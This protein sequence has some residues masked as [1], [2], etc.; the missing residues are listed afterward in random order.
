MDAASAGAD[1]IAHLEDD[2]LWRPH[3]LRSALDAVAH[4]NADFVSSSSELFSGLPP[5]VAPPPGHVGTSGV[6]DF[7]IASSWVMRPAVW[8]A[9]GRY[10]PSYRV[11]PDNDWLGR[12]NALNRFRRVHLVEPGLRPPGR[13]WVANVAKVSWVVPCPEASQAEYDRLTA[14]YGHIPW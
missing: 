9:A 6:F 13:A 12:V 8:T 5:G 4:Y 14:K 1:F 2:D 3:H 11:H 10:D 7:P